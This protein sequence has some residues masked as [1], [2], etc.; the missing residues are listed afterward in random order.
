MKRMSSF[1]QQTIQNFALL[2]EHRWGLPQLNTVHWTYLET[3]PTLI[4]TVDEL[5]EG[6]DYSLHWRQKTFFLQTVVE[7]ARADTCPGHV[8]ADGVECHLLFS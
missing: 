7:V 4:T 3:L 2:V 5:H 6:I 8:R 1:V